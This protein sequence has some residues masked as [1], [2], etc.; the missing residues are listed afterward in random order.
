MSAWIHSI[1]EIYADFTN[2]QRVHLFKIKASPQSVF[3]SMLIYLD[4]YDNEVDE[5]S[6]LTDDFNDFRY[7]ETLVEELERKRNAEGRFADRAKLMQ[8]KQV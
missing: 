4:L 8:E 5:K 2:T 7:V 1:K 6:S 3:E